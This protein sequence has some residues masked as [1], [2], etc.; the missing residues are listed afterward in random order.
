MNAKEADFKGKTKLNQI[1]VGTKENIGVSV[2][3]RN[4]NMFLWLN[5]DLY[6]QNNEGRLF[7]I[8]FIEVPIKRKESEE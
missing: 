2:S 6:Y 3:P 8:D 1:R 5:G 7:I 4:D